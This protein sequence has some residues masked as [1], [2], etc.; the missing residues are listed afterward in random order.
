MLERTPAMRQRSQRVRGRRPQRR[1]TH[2]RER[3]RFG[4]AGGG[5]QASVAAPGPAGE[6]RQQRRH[7][8]RPPLPRHHTMACGTQ[9]IA[10]PAQRIA[11]VGE[12][13]NAFFVFSM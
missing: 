4:G 9:R 6:A 7:R 13:S 3:A 10:R 2:P 12:C 8:E 1:A 11:T 5:G